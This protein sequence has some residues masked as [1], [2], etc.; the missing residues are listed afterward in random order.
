M[1][2]KNA[3]ECVFVTGSGAWAVSPRDALPVT[4]P[5]PPVTRHTPPVSRSRHPATASHGHPG[6]ATAAWDVKT[7]KKPYKLVILTWGLA[8]GQYASQQ[9]TLL[10]IFAW[11]EVTP[12]AAEPSRDRVQGQVRSGHR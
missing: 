1:A 5:P 9:I 12:V 3:R 6:A 10:F 11:P 7:A 8:S 2:E 4:P